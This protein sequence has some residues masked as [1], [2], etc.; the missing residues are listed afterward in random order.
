MKK[1]FN[2]AIIFCIFISCCLSSCSLNKA[3]VSQTANDNQESN[4]TVARSPFS[5]GMIDVEQVIADNPSIFGENVLIFESMDDVDELLSNMQEA[6]PMQLRSIY[7]SLGN[8]NPIIESHIIYDSVMADVQDQLSIYIDDYIHEDDMDELMETFVENMQQNFPTFCIIGEYVL[9]D[10]NVCTCVSPL[11]VIDER[12][13]CNDHNIFIVGEIVFKIVGDYLMTCS[14]E[15]YPYLAGYDNLAV[16]QQYLDT[17]NINYITEED[18]IICHIDSIEPIAEPLVP[19]RRSIHLI[20]NNI[21]PDNHVLQFGRKNELYA[22][23]AR[24]TVY[25][26][27]APFQTNY[28]CNLT[29]K[30]YYKGSLS[31]QKISC[32]F[33]C[34]AHGGYGDLVCYLEFHRY[35]HGLVNVFNQPILIN[36]FKER[37]FSEN[38]YG[39]AYYPTLRTTVDI[40]HYYIDLKQNENAHDSIYIREYY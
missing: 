10:D 14:V 38:N 5:S 8:N 11:G 2:C 22:V 26:Y 29:I 18:L 35:F 9:P 1:S 20:G 17:G 19:E 4:V 25:P 16:L 37:T 39:S 40:I 15:N 34:D 7:T 33:S 21:V 31:K 23:N 24:V 30:N 28:R 36:R 6:D 3:D 13:L 12:V 32:H 27:W